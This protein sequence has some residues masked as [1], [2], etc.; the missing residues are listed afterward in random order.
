MPRWILTHRFEVTQLPEPALWWLS[1]V[2]QHGFQSVTRRDNLIDAG[3]NRMFSKDRGDG[4]AERAGFW[5][6]GNIGD[7]RSSLIKLHVHT[8]SRAANTR[9]FL[10]AGLSIIKRADMRDVCGKLKN[11]IVIELAHGAYIG[12]QPK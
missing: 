5:L 8:H 3:A 12:L 10:D 9:D 11:A 7:M 2:F 6:N 4:L 1:A